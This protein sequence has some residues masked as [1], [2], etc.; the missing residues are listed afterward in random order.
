VRLDVGVVQDRCIG[1]GQCALTEPS[2]FGQDDDGFVTLLDD[3]PA[4]EAAE[5]A[6]LAVTLCPVQ[7]LYATPSP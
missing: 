6:G 2:V 1:S 3:A 4:G 7:A 5:R